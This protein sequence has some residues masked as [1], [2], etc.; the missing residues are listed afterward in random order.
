[1]EKSAI[2]NDEGDR[3][4]QLREVL[5]NEAIISG[6]IA[7]RM[8]IELFTSRQRHLTKSFCPTTI[9]RLY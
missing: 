5:Y 1:M 3:S 9:H 8:L 6:H 2:K 4:S 7:Q